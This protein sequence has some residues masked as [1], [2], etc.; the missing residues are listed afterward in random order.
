MLLRVKNYL[1]D[2]LNTEF[3]RY[4]LFFCLIG[5]VA[6]LSWGAYKH[7]FYTVEDCWLDNLEGVN[8]KVGRDA[9]VRACMRKYK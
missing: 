1:W 3:K 9:V 8:S 4:F 7:F 5:V 6:S 2:E